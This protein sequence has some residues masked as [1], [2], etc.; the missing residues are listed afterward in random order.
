MVSI[1]M[2]ACR[3][4]VASHHRDHL[5]VERQVEAGVLVLGREDVLVANFPNNPPSR[6]SAQ[7]STQWDSSNPRHAREDMRPSTLTRGCPLSWFSRATQARAGHVVEAH[8]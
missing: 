3:R 7:Q 8:P 5:G 6:D 1:S 2:R 4:A